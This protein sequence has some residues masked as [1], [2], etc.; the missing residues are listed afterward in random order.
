MFQEMSFSNRGPVVANLPLGVE[1]LLFFK[2]V[3]IARFE[4]PALVLHP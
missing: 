3:L 2:I 1:I 4:A